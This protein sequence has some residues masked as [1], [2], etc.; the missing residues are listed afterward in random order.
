MNNVDYV[1][2]LGATRTTPAYL[3]DALNVDIDRNGKASRRQGYKLLFSGAAHSLFGAA[4][5]PFG[6]VVFDG[7]LCWFDESEAPPEPLLPVD[8]N[9]RMSYVYSNGRIYWSNGQVRG[10]VLADKSIYPGGIDTPP[11]Q[12]LL[13]TT[14]TG[15]R[16]KAE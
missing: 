15:D 4:E 13:P 3:R 9:A 11:I 14:A 6:L 2:E 12:P 16:T 7:K 10:F 1:H 5:L 8:P